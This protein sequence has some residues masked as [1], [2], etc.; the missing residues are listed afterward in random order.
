MSLASTSQRKK[1]EQCTHCAVDLYHKVI[2]APV[3]AYNVLKLS[4]DDSFRK[5]TFLDIIGFNFSWFKNYIFVV[6]L[7]VVKKGSTLR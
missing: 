7:V 1:T 2:Q 4:T 3:G 5:T 6:S